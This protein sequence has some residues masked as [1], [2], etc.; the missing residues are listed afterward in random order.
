[1]DFASS[2]AG[3]LTP[4]IMMMLALL[5]ILL[6]EEEEPITQHDSALTGQAYYDELM[7]TDNPHRFR[8]VAKMEKA[9]FISLLDMLTTTGELTGGPLIHPGEKLMILINACCGHNNRLMNERWQHSGSTISEVIHEVVFCILKCKHLVFT[10][11]HPHDAPAAKIAGNPQYDPWFLPCVGAIDGSHISAVNL[12]DNFRDRKGQ[13]TQNVLASIDFDM[14]FMYVLVGWE[15]SAHDG[16]ILEDAIHKNFP[17]LKD[18]FYLADAGFGLSKFFL[19]PYRGVRYHL[20]EFGEGTDRP[21]NKEELFNLRHAK[22][23]NI[24]ERAFGVIKKRFP[25]LVNMKN[26]HFAFQCDLVMCCFILHNFIRM[27]EAFESDDEISDDEDDDNEEEKVQ[28]V[29]DYA[30]YREA[31]VSEK[32]RYN[33]AKVWRDNM[34]LDM[35]NSYNAYLVRNYL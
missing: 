5:P 31:N 23:R 7:L 9:T 4:E 24:I 27:Q 14:V 8:S 30:R 2:N 3:A 1:M 35:W 29:V 15:G 10:N 13:V 32:T 28:E 18:K 11:P 21:Q 33:E 22:L 12:D 34:A 26:Y 16:K 20:K 6:D 25:L 19:T 17:L